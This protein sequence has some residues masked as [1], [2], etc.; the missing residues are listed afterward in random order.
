MMPEMLKEI[1]QILESG[2]CRETSYNMTGRTGM[3]TGQCYVTARVLKK[4]FGGEIL[5]H[6]SG[7]G[8]HYWNRLPN[9]EVYDF[10]SKQWGGDGIHPAPS[11]LE[12]CP[13]PSVK[14][15]GERLYHRAKRFFD[16]VGHRL[17]QLRDRI[18]W[19]NDL[20]KSSGPLSG[21]AESPRRTHRPS[22]PPR[23]FTHYFRNEPEREGH[24]EP[25]GYLY[26]NLFSA[27]GVEPG[28]LIYAVQIR[29]GRMRLFGR[30][31]VADVIS[32]HR[33][34]ARRLGLPLRSVPK[35]RDFVQPA[36]STPLLIGHAAPVVPDDFA[37]ALRFLSK[38][39]TVPL[40]FRELNRLDG[41]TLRGVRILS[42]KS[43]EL[44]DGLLPPMAP[45]N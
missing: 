43:A 45:V 2:W 44:L 35:A 29:D 12:L 11:L 4:V 18:S 5:Y 14:P 22:R 25:F 24:G 16:S 19:T 36:E 9:G 34:A 37:R 17:E 41:Q 26:S 1:R 32:S 8:G 42:E 21:Q 20:A 3:D 28:D 15:V 40:R 13:N 30:V 27:R 33:E 23:H 10:T 31:R 6:G 39:G 38:K 7:R